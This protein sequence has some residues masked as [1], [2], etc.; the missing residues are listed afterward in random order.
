CVVTKADLADP[1][2]VLQSL[3]QL[4]PGS[5][6]HAVSAVTGDGLRGL[7]DALA[8]LIAAPP[9][10]VAPAAASLAGDGPPRETGVI[11]AALDFGPRRE[12]EPE[13]GARVT[14]HLRGAQALARLARLGGRF[15]QVR[16]DP[17]LAAR[18]GDR[19]VVR[20][21]EAGD[22][23]S[24]TLGGGIVLDPGARRHPTSN[25]VIV[26]LTRIW[27]GQAP[28]PPEGPRLPPRAR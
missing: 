16:L 17:P 9:V 14:V 13:H 18:A 10:R 1:T 22:G 4:V 15:W 24:Y 28:L 25:E 12:R 23:V 21:V 8:Q 26:R 2:R 5:S 3:D 19:F 20:S 11:D 7:R 6:A 27:R